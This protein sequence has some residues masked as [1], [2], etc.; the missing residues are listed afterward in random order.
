MPIRKKIAEESR[1]TLRV[2]EKTCPDCGR[3]LSVR[4]FYESC[5][6]ADGYTTYCKTCMKRQARKRYKESVEQ[7]KDKEDKTK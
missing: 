3:R 4:H 2:T 6:N 7:H 5:A 1:A